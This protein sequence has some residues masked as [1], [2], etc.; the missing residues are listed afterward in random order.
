MIELACGLAQT[1]I[2]PTAGNYLFIVAGAQGGTIPFFNVPGGLGATVEATVFLQQ[3]AV[4]PIIVAGQ[5]ATVGPNGDSGGGGLSAVYTNGV[6]ALPT[7]VAGMATSFLSHIARLPSHIVS[8]NALCNVL[9][10]FQG[11]AGVAHFLSRAEDSHHQRALIC[12]HPQPVGHPVEAAQPRGLPGMEVRTF[13][14]DLLLVLGTLACILVTYKSRRRM[15]HSG[16]CASFYARH[17]PKSLEPACQSWSF[18]RVAM[19]KA[20]ETGRRHAFQ[21]TV[22]AAMEE[23]VGP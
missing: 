20:P 10:L 9:Y 3:G 2:A 19:A 23:A 15:W 1:F 21:E 12:L 17:H 11:V 22:E 13:A 18:P 7:I 16:S 14:R 4:V 5:G 8:Y 6:G